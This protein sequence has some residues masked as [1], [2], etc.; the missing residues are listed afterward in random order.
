MFRG[1]CR[2]NVSVLDEAHVVVGE[3]LIGGV[4]GEI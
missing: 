3:C 2:C 1:G 4:M